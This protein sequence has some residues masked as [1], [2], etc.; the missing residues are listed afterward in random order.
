MLARYAQTLLSPIKSDFTTLVNNR[1]R[2]I[3]SAPCVLHRHP[4]VNKDLLE[5]LKIVLKHAKERVNFIWARPCLFKV[6]CKDEL[7]DLQC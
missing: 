3:V 2:N 4:L 5:Y 1:T 7:V 6:L